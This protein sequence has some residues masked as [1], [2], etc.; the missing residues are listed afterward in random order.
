RSRRTRVMATT[1]RSIPKPSEKRIA[2]FWSQVTGDPV[3]CW[4]W[5]GHKNKKGYGLFHVAGKQHRTHRLAYLLTFGVD[6]AELCV[7][8]RCDNPACCNPAHLFIGT[9]ADNTAD[10]MRKK[11]N[12]HG[13]N[14]GRKMRLK[15]SRAGTGNPA[16]ILTENEVIEI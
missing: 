10:M 15:K 2:F 14:T 3:A 5:P 6:P 13:D 9:P 8:H 16:A 12:A 7:L 1:H 4:P 11:R